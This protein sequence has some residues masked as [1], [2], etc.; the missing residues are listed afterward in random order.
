M[1]AIFLGSFDP[2]HIGHFM[3]LDTVINYSYIDDSIKIFV[4]PT[5]QNPNKGKSTDFY[6]RFK[7]CQLMFHKFYN[8]IIVDDIENY[9]NWTYTYE[10]LQYLES[11]E[12]DYIKKGFYWIIT[13]ETLK[14]LLDNKWKNSDYILNTFKDR[15]IILG[16]EKELILDFESNSKYF[17]IPWF[18]NI[19]ST[20][21]RDRVK[22]NENIVGAVNILTNDYIKENNLYKT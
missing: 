18:Y 7:M 1:Q 13:T 2:P 10:M 11:G 15:F 3:C 14:E 20:Q 19:H 9:H 16:K 12:D 17:Q 6:K 21:I 8:N 22:N 5:H 4:I